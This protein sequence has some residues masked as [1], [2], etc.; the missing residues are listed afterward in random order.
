MG[1]CKSA[2]MPIGYTR[3]IGHD[4]DLVAL[5]G[6]RSKHNTYMSVP[7]VWTMIDSHTVV[8]FASYGWVGLVVA[9]AIGWWFTSMFYRQSAKVPGF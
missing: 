7:L 3:L 2:A 1:S 4:P 5:A 9:V 8:P 6:T